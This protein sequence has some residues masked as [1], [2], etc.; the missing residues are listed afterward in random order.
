V[1]D[2]AESSADPDVIWCEKPIASQVSAAH[3][4]VETCNQTDTE[5]VVNHSFRFTNKLQQLHHLIQDRNLLGD[6]RSVS[7]QYRMELMR[8]STHLLDTVLYLLDVQADQVSGYI[9]GQNEAVESLGAKETVD[10]AG[11]GGH[12]V[13]NDG[14]F[15]TVDCTIPRNMSSMTLS[16]IGTEGKL[17][18]N[19]DDG[20]WRYWTLENGEHVEKPLPEID[21]AWTWDDDYQES[22]LNAALHV[23]NLLLGESENHSPGTEALRSLEIIVAFYLSH[24]T[25]STVDIPLKQP[26]REI[27]VTSW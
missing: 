21:G 5:L 4:M 19:N 23:Q 7:T 25:G 10:D 11:G 20:E 3:E 9:N 2:A 16:F 15:V 18:L 26:L 13:M 14:T 24:Y 27:T 17:Y 6:I 1:I 12:I 22:F 8:N